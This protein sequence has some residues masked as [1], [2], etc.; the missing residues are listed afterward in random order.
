MAGAPDASAEMEAAPTP[1]AMSDTTNP[2]KMP[3]G[4]AKVNGSTTLQKRR[5]L[6]GRVR[7]G[8]GQAEVQD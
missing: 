2:T 5:M 4:E 8:R 7:Q 6:R 3:T 1:C